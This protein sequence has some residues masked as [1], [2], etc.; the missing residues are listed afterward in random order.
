MVCKP[1]EKGGLGVIDIKK[2]KKAL[3]MKKI[4]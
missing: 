3:L 4:R 2:Q 1:K